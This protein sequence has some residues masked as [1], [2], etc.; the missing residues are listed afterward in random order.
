MSANQPAPS[1][2]SLPALDNGQA[3]QVS[4]GLVSNTAGAPPNLV[5]DIA[6]PLVIAIAAPL[7]LKRTLESEKFRALFRFPS[8]KPRPSATEDA[9]D[10]DFDAD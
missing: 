6:L 8:A 5:W 3:G 4:S 9:Q 1:H 10:I 7:L 2:T